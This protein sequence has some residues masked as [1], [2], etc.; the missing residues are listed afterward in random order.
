MKH[1]KILQP[2]NGYSMLTLF[3]VLFAGSMT[4]VIGYEIHWLAAV[5]RVSAAFILIAL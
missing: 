5:A 3:L 1:E 2:I 4:G